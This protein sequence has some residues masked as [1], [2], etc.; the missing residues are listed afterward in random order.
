LLASSVST[1]VI[2]SAY[3]LAAST[4]ARAFAIRE[5]AMSSIALVIFLMDCVERIRRRSTRICAAM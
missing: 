3:G 5:V 4:R 1:A 2:C